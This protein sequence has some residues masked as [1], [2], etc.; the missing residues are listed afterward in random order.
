M[1]QLTFADRPAPTLPIFND[2][3]PHIADEFF[4]YHRENPKVYQLF[5]EYASRLRSQGIFHYGAK[6]IM[7]RIR[8][9]FEVD[10]RSADF[11]VNNNY[12]SC[13]PAY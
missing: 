8:W 2:I 3:A 12:A 1:T 10:Q 9:H 6:A 13:F 4:K 11:K 5:R 7:E